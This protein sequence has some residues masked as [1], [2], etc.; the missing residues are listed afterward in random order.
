M[1]NRDIMEEHMI[2]YKKSKGKATAQKEVYG[3]SHLNV[4]PLS[5][6]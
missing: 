1:Q 3:A 5:L 4:H 2:Q 6:R